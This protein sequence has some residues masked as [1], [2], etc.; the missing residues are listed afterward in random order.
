MY[1]SRQ[2]KE[3]GQE[4]PDTYTDAG[5]S[6]RLYVRVLDP[7]GVEV[8]AVLGGAACRTE[9]RRGEVPVLIVVRCIAATV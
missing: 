9:T 2:K 6:L 4:R 3:D 8:E 1:I 5:L 7:R